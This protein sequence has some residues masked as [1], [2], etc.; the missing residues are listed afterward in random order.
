MSNTKA[1]VML[2]CASLF[3]SGN[4]IVGKFAFLTDIP[5]LSLVFYRWLLVWLILLPFTYKEILKYKDVILKNLPLLFFLGLASV[6]LFNSF[7]YLSLI[8][9]QVI[10]ATLLNAA[11]PAIIILLCFLFK[12][13]STNKFQ[14]VGLIVSIIGVISILTKLNLD[15]LI[16]LD[17]NKG[18]L[19]MIAGVLSWGIYSSLLKKKNFTLPLL[20]LVHII[21]TFGLICVTPQYIY[22]L[23][24]GQIIKFDSN[25]VYILIFLAIFPSIGSYYCWAGAV[26]IIGAN[27]AGISL[28]LIPLFSSI[29][30]IILFKEQFQF[31]H[32][33]GALLIILGLFLSNKEIKG[34]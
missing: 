34:A 16:S 18:D 21:C 32:L 5:P 20:T 3:W 24:Q 10:N 13:E 2:V 8:H 33:I 31:F 1:Y 17:F 9:T 15:I 19:I 14:I 22:E 28:S 6:G 27:R 23:S 4:F 25:L 12:I 11:I 7:T 26:S 30:A 29:M